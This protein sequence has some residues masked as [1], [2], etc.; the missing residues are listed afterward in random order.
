[1]VL[2]FGEK[3]KVLNALFFLILF[4]YHLPQKAHFV[5]GEKFLPLCIF[6]FDCINLWLR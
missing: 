5:K 4:Y 1:M 6:F 3:N 2:Y